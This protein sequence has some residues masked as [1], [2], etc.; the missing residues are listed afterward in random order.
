MLRQC[1]Y[2][3]IYLERAD[4]HFMNTNEGIIEGVKNQW[5]ALSIKCNKNN[6]FRRL[7]LI[8]FTMK[9]QVIV[10]LLVGL[11]L[12]VQVGVSPE[13]K[14]SPYLKHRNCNFLIKVC[15]TVM[16]QHYWQLGH[17]NSCSKTSQ[18]L[19]DKR[20][21]CT[22]IMVVDLCIILK[23]LF[24]RLFVIESHYNFQIFPHTNCRL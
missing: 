6:Y 15:I 5:P 20:I 18:K 9:Q 19:E 13:L 14:A 11:L 21:G 23:C 2:H 1:L 8:D 22:N 10:M 3:Q 4:R 24:F 12:Q 7:R 16:F 17:P